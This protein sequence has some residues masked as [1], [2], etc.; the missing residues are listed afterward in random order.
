MYTT[1]K[2][3]KHHVLVYILSSCPLW[4]DMWCSAVVL[5]SIT[6][7]TY[8]IVRLVPGGT[9]SKNPRDVVRGSKVKN[10]FLHL[11][12]LPSYGRK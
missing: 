9:H 4:T 8:F 11:K 3:C 1:T 2:F 7:G 6:G 10:V 5:S 12:V